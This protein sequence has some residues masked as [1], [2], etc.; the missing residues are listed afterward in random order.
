MSCCDAV[1][2]KVYNRLPLDA[3]EIVTADDEGWLGG[4][5]GLF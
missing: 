4:F 2:A 3:G 5:L 1:L